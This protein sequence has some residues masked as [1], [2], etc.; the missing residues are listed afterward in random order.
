MNRFQK[1]EL[2]AMKA[3]D[4]WYDVNYEEFIET[5]KFTKRR[6]SFRRMCRNSARNLCK[7]NPNVKYGMRYYKAIRKVCKL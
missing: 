2:K 5:E 7:K 4:N 6:R 3:Y 1:E